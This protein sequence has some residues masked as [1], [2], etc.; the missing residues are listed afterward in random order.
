MTRAT[1]TLLWQG[2]PRAALDIFAPSPLRLG[3]GLALFG[4]LLTPMLVLRGAGITY[5]VLFLPAM[6]AG[7]WLCLGDALWDALRRWRT[8]YYLSDERLVIDTLWPWGGKRVEYRLRPD[9]VMRLD[10][11]HVRVLYGGSGP[12]ATAIDLEYLDDAV[13]V[14]EQVQDAL[15]R[16]PQNS[17][18]ATRD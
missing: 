11:P 17:E 5:W 10:R 2:R 14:A 7:F 9:M 18:A 6:A 4:G 8:R 1:E 16:A 13:Q 3:L 15:R 12:E